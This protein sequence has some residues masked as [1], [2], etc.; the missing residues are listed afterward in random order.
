MCLNICINWF[1][2]VEYI[3]GPKRVKIVQTTFVLQH[4]RSY[5]R[6]DLRESNERGDGLGQQRIR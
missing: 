6:L 3:F 5:L 1:N 4:P 2:C